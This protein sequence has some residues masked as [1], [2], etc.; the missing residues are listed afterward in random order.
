MA[1]RRRYKRRRTIKKR[2]TGYRRKRYTRYARRFGARFPRVRGY[3]GYR[4]KGKSIMGGMSPPVIHNSKG[5]GLTVRHREFVGSIVLTDKNG[6]VVPPA[7]PGDP[8]AYTGFR[9]NQTI[10][11][12]PGNQT[13]V[14]LKSVAPNW[15]EYEWHGMLIEYKP[16]TALATTSGAGQMGSV[17]VGTHY[18]VYESPYED[19]IQMLNSEFTTSGKPQL[20]QLH[21][22]ECKRSQTPVSRKWVRAPG[23]ASAQ[24]DNRLYDHGRVEIAT[25]GIPGRIGDVIGE[26][27][28]T[29]EVCLYKPKL[30]LG[31]SFLVEGDVETFVFQDTNSTSGAQKRFENLK[32]QGWEI[33]KIMPHVIPNSS[34]NGNFFPLGNVP[35]D[36][37]PSYYFNK[38]EIENGDIFRILMYSWS[39]KSGVSTTLQQDTEQAVFNGCKYYAWYLPDQLFEIASPNGGSTSNYVM[40]EYYLQITNKN[41]SR[42]YVKF[43]AA[44]GVTTSAK[45]IDHLVLVHKLMNRPIALGNPLGDDTDYGHVWTDGVEDVVNYDEL[46]GVGVF[47]PA[48]KW[49]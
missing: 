48:I 14:W 25:E 1:Y 46:R 15:K 28:V 13:F 32:T 20:A 42:V 23:D 11:L 7:P 9:V 26:L 10:N 34:M 17:M 27:W 22:I 30:T 35:G 47:D 2:K 49:E 44:F 45:V 12:N 39:D 8:A 41:Q 31:R 36:Y 33:G 3:G 40:K 38:D 18:D 16:L 29:Y 37:S 5:D 21:P 6:G 43:P 19:K 24:A 4:F